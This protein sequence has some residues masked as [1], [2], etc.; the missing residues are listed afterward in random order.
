MA[1]L[2]VVMNIG[3]TTS[4]L[5]HSSSIDV[6]HRC[7]LGTAAFH[8]LWVM[9]LRQSLIPLQRRLQIYHAV[10]VSIML[11]NCGSWT[12]PKSVLSHLDKC[13]RSHLRSILDIHWPNT[14]SNGLLYRRCD[15]RPLS[16][17]VKEAHWRMLGHILRMPTDTPA[18]LAIQFALKEATEYKGRRGRHQ[19]NLLE[20]IRADL[21]RHQ[22]ELQS[23]ADMRILRELATDKNKWRALGKKD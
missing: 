10:V 13:H 1:K 17:I 22:L 19:T 2:S 23:D 6:L 14:I 3:A 11:Y 7:N 8:S 15:T 18:Q 21:R 4:H 9:W 12:V 5:G 16:E 20:T